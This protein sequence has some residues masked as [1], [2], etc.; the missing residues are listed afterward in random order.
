[1]WLDKTS[2]IWLVPGQRRKILPGVSK[3]VG[4]HGI[5]HSFCP[6]KKDNAECKKSRRQ[7]ALFLFEEERI[8][9]E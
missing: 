5:Q 3:V 9:E 2:Q 7:T 8:W 4:I 1:M 6:K